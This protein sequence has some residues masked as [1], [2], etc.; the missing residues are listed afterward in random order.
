MKFNTQIIASALLASAVT[1]ASFT[2]SEWTT[3]YNTNTINGAVSSHSS[4]FAIAVVPITTGTWGVKASTGAAQLEA[5]SIAASASNTITSQ[6]SVAT[7]DSNDSQVSITD[8]D[9]NGSHDSHSSEDSVA[10]RNVILTTLLRRDEAPTNTAT[11]SSLSDA[12]GDNSSDSNHYD[13]ED[14]AGS[15]TTSSSS[16]SNSAAS[17]SSV[18]SSLQTSAASSGDG[19][20]STSTED[21]KDSS[22]NNS[23][24]IQAVSCSIKGSLSMTLAN[25][26]LT[27]S[28]GRIG[29]I[30]S[31]RQFQFD[32]PP[33]AGTIYAKGWSITPEGY[34]AIGDTEIFYRCLSGGFYNLYDQNVAY[35]CDP[36]RLV[37]TA[38]GE[39]C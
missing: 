12:S 19:N 38:F 15:S 5:S 36:I 26:V 29:A 7:S 8:N 27:D 6:A 24:P 39:N 13:Q 21:N 23:D 4:S 31:N 16:D 1:A 35:Q 3:L 11:D 28:N 32:G 33:Q 37:A 20:T 9:S 22:S 14:S 17:T 18:Y 34:L 25:G 2:N 10:K 30:V